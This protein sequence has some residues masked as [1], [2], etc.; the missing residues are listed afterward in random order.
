M[1]KNEIIK[2]MAKHTNLT[3]KDC[4]LCLNALKQVISRALERGEDISLSGFGKFYVKS[5][6]KRNSFNPQ[7]G[8]ISALKERKL[9]IF[10]ASSVLKA[11]I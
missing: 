5:Y 8:K 7:T 9:P 2:S 6:A 3:Q 10:K 4:I 11:K 1:N